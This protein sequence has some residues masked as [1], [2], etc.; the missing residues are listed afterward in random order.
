M[1]D[2]VTQ[3]LIQ[4]I[5]NNSKRVRDGHKFNC[6]M[7]V[8]MGE[9]RPDTK[10]RGGLKLNF[11]GFVYNCFNC[12]FSTGY[13]SGLKPTKKCISLLKTLGADIN[14]IPIDIRLGT[15]TRYKKQDIKIPEKF[16]KAKFPGELYSIV[17]LITAGFTEPNFDKVV[18]FMANETPFLMANKSICW[19]PTTLHDMNCRF[20]MPF[21][22]KS[23]LVGWTARYFEKTPPSSK[24]K[25]M[26]NRPDN[27]MYNMDILDGTAEN[28]LVVEGPTDAQA[29]N[30]VAMLT[31]TINDVE[32]EILRRSGKN[33][34]IIPDMETTGSKLV[35]SAAKY[36][37]QVSFPIWPKSVKDCSDAVKAYGRLYTLTSI[38]ENI[39]SG[40]PIELETKF[41]TQLM[42]R[43]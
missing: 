13:S 9:P 21:Y 23:D 19:S 31:N 28:I 37:F 5:P 12:K 24:P 39:H 36:G 41:K 30:G 7:C 15:N 33:V 38:Y 43:T 22:Y 17:D 34:I 40:S 2:I 25:Y 14:Q 42:M 35:Q 10:M 32:A 1:T 27:Y 11:D 18:E 26:M 16:G 8:Q 6:P 3:L 4:N 20:I 29:I